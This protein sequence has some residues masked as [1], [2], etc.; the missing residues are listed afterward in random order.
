MIDLN[1]PYKQLSKIEGYEDFVDYYIDINGDVYST[2]R[3]RIKKIKPC[4]A[5][6]KNRRYLRVYLYSK[7]RSIVAYI[8]VLMVK[9]FISKTKRKK[10][11]YHKS[12]NIQDNRLENLISTDKKRGY[13]GHRLGRP[14]KDKKEVVVNHEEVIKE[15]EREFLI[16]D[17]SIEKIKLVHR[18]AIQKGLNVSDSFSF[19]E[20]IIE[21]LLDEYCSRKG[22][23]KIIHQMQNS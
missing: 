8:H 18:A 22:L 20:E 21:E 14:R 13:P 6:S 23:K 4:Y 3:N 17:E 11:T 7:K 16:G 1:V 2:K 5:G 10:Y 12:G 15:L 19:I 9:A